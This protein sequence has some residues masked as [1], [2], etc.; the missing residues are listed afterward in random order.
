[1]PLDFIGHVTTTS[2]AATLTPVTPAGTLAGDLSIVQLSGERGTPVAPF[3]AGWVELLPAPEA[4][5]VHRLW[6]K[7]LAFPGETGTWTF[8]FPGFKAIGENSIIRQ[9]L[10]PM[11]NDYAAA[12][13]A[14]AVVTWTWPAVTPTF[15]VGIL[16]FSATGIVRDSWVNFLPV[17]TV[18]RYL[19]QEIVAGGVISMELNTVGTVLTFG[20]TPPGLIGPWTADMA[21]GIARAG[22]VRTV[23][24]RAPEPPP[25]PPIRKLKKMGGSAASPFRPPV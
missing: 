20:N 15:T 6:W 25:P 14:P 22:S 12:S 7:E 16:L 4:A 18:E 11:P 9:Q 17:P 21:S 8:D 1:M 5:V 24:I 13:I 19:S 10:L 23:A 3:P 2:L